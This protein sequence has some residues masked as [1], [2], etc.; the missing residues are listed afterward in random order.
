MGRR[1]SGVLGKYLSVLIDPPRGRPFG[2]GDVY[3]IIGLRTA[4]SSLYPYFVLFRFECQ[5]ILHFKKIIGI[6]DVHPPQ[7]L[8]EARRVREFL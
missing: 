3:R 7:G 6:Y 5:I 8:F 1:L 2:G 4:D